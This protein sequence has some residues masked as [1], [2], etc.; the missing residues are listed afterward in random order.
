LYKRNYS[1]KEKIK[2]VNKVLERC[3]SINSV[4]LSYNI[5][6][7]TLEGWIRNYQPMESKAFCKKGWTKRTSIEKK[8]AVMDYLNGQ[9]SG[10][11]VG[12]KML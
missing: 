1:P 6:F 12:L 11:P 5:N 7:I 3:Q 4:A 9:G 2:I 8:S 10:Q